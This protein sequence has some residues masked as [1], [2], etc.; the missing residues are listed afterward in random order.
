MSDQEKKLVKR[1][2]EAGLADHTVAAMPTLGS[3]T[4]LR[5]AGYNSG[6]AGAPRSG[7]IVT[8]LRLTQRGLEFTHNGRAFVVGNGSWVYTIEAL[9][10]E[11]P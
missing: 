4:R 3:Q 5:L 10:P 6:P 9:V 1:V 2:V 11:A 8:E 7:A